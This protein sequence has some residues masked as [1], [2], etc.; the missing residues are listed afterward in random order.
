MTDT[1]LNAELKN[2]LRKSGTATVGIVCKDGIVLGADK[3]ASL[4]ETYFIAN[5]RAMKI[6]KL[7]DNI[8]VTFAGL[9]SDM[10]LLIKIVR[11]ELKLK[12]VRT[13]VSPTVKEAA[14]LFGSIV[15]QNI[16]KFSPIP[17]I[18]HFIMGGRDHEGLHLY[19]ICVDG[20]IDE[21]KNFLTSGAYGSIMGYG[22]L[23]NE[24][25]EGMTVEEGKKLALKV[26][27]TAIKRDASVGEP[28]NMVIVDEKGVG[29]IAEFK[30]LEISKK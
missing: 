30:A 15:Y 20:T 11:A 1:E 7:T 10:Q 5:L 4:G 13:K 9:V 29:E 6:F 16:R 14:N 22:I 17:G 24:W 19:E 26:L 27:S 28:F 18:T 25:K 21:Y 12:S 8:A 3:R 23:E 2:K